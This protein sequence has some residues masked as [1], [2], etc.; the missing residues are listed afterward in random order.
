[1]LMSFFVCVRMTRYQID[2]QQRKRQKK[3]DC[4][5]AK[6]QKEILLQQWYLQKQTHYA[7]SEDEFLLI[8]KI[9]TSDDDVA[10]MIHDSYY[11]KS[12]KRMSRFQC[13]T[14]L[15]LI[16]SSS[17]S[18]S[19]SCRCI[20]G[21]YSNILQLAFSSKT[22]E[23]RSLLEL[24]KSQDSLTDVANNMKIPASLLSRAMLWNAFKEHL[25]DIQDT[26]MNP[27]LVYLLST[28]L[29][30]K[31]WEG[32]IDILSIYKLNDKSDADLK[33]VLL[34]FERRPAFFVPG[35]LFPQHLGQM[36]LEDI[37]W[38]SIFKLF[39]FVQKQHCLLFVQM[40]RMFGSIF[41]QCNIPVRVTEPNCVL[42]FCYQEVT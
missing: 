30:E 20:P 37:N 41:Y 28:M 22:Q 26:K 11:Q 35:V 12:I 19:S 6:N 23:T 34:Q 21:H 10:I 14:G 2:D 40:L 16:S 18:S 5:G 27:L 32:N 31:D 42:E 9:M 4:Q 29:I 1:M 17:S 13:R 25:F 39:P 24:A 33:E 38:N 36:D 3:T 8:L 15:T 7:C